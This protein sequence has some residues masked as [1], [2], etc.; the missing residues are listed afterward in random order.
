MYF[1]LKSLPGP[2]FANFH[3]EPSVKKE[4]K[5]CTNGHASVIKMAA[6][7]TDFENHLKIFFRTKK[8]LKLSLGIEHYGWEI[9]QLCN[10]RLTVNLFMV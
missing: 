3:V 7:L 9:Y 8:A 10:P 2:I 5:F 4:L 6:I 1:L